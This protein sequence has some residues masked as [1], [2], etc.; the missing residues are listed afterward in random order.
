[1]IIPNKVCICCEKLIKG[2]A[3]KKFCNEHCRNN[4]NNLLNADANNLVRNINHALGKN[5]R[6]LESFIPTDEEMG[7]ASKEAMLQ[8]G[9]QFKYF[10]HIYTN[11]KGTQYFCCYDYAYLLLENDWYLIV[12][13]SN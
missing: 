11:K 3:D 2:R 4:Y 1:M 12:K 13:N 5:R 8:S 6:I 10:T 9:F 7:K